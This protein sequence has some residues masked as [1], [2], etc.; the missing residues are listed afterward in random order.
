M[1]AFLAVLAIFV[2]LAP[3]AICDDGSENGMIK[4]FP[5]WKNC[6]STTQLQFIDFYLDHKPDLKTTLNNEEVSLFNDTMT[7]V[8]FSLYFPLLT[9]PHSALV[10]EKTSSSPKL[11]SNSLWTRTSLLST[12]K[13]P[14]SP[15]CPSA[16][17][18]MTDA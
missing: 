4:F 7:L 16:K 8:K 12:A 2:V 17:V 1:K 15:E 14:L 11:K 13:S 5:K 6:D 18:S 9:F 10:K 3:S